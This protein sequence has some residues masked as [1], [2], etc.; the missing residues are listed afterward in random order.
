MKT[1]ALR[2]LAGA[3]L[4]LALILSS[5]ACKN[6]EPANEGRI[7]IQLYSVRGAVMD[8]PQSAV[9]RLSE[10]GYNSFELVQWGG[11]TTVFNLDP[12]EFRKIC[13]DNGVQVVSTHSSLQ[14]DPENEEVVM[15]RWRQL[16]QIQS[17][18]GGSYFVIPSYKVEYTKAGLDAMCAYFNKVGKVASEYGLKLG[19]HNHHKEFGKLEDEDV[20]MWEYLVQHTDPQ[21]VCFEL[22]VYWCQKGGTD[23]VEMLKKYPTRVELLHIKDD[24]V[25]GEGGEMDFASIFSQ[26][27]A[28]G[29]HDFFVEL[30]TP[31]ELREAVNPD[32][33]KY[34]RAQIDDALFEAA[35]KSIKFLKDNNFAK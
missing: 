30:E 1:N 15:E 31:K 22:D 7:G 5:Q 23:P 19:Y 16:F 17:S 13:D 12:W 24:F 25:L 26:F 8:N 20:T 33:S 28:N 11:D 3:S 14:E 6:A 10:M 2:H 35:S 29:M 34:S 21:Y 18:V 4:G 32:G 9:E 27:Y